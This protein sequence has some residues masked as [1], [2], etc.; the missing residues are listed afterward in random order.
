MLSCAGLHSISLIKVFFW[1]NV[2]NMKECSSV[3]PQ[4]FPFIQ[5]LSNSSAKLVAV[6]ELFF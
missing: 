3:V 5:I 1:V 6:H 4:K 2:L